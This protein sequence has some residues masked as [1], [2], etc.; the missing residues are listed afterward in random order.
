MVA[1]T[2]T[3]IPLV[4]NGGGLDLTAQ[5]ATPTQLTLQFTNTGQ[6]FLAVAAG[7]ISETVIVD[8]SVTI[9]GQTVAN[10]PSV[11]LTNA[12]TVLFGP[13][14]SQIDTPGTNLMTVM[15]STLTAIQ[16]ALLRFTGVS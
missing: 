5:L 8:I 13:F 6:E 12:H 4:P 9:L 10:F 2:L 16:V 3:P 7:A 14:S 15:L 11:S 1:Q